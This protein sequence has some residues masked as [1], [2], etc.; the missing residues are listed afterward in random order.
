MGQG[1]VEALLILGGNPV[2][3]AP[4][5]LNFVERLQKVPLRIRHG[6]FV[7]E[8][9]YQCLWHL[10]ETHYLE[11]WS[12]AR[13]YDGTASIVQPL[14]EPLCEGAGPPTKCWRS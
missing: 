5:D 3:N 2:Y 9:S 1:R 7:D 11:A 13:A 14:I 6:L 8:T 4:A 10:P 12:D